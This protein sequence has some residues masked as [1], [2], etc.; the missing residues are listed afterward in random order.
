MALKR[1]TIISTKVLN[2]LQ[3]AAKPLSI[4]QILDLLSKNNLHPNKSTLYR[5]IEKL[6]NDNVVT[7]ITLANSKKFYEL[8]NRGHHHH[9][10]CESC[11]NIICLDNCHVELHGINL[12]NLLPSPSFK[13]SHH[14]FNLYGKCDQCS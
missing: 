14:D 9:F 12:K 5:L 10:F 13:I 1:K 11:D 6:T 7:S 8:T 4:T 2:L 3:M